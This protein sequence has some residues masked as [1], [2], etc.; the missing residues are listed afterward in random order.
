M[1]AERGSVQRKHLSPTDLAEVRE[2]LRQEGK[3]VVQ[4]H[5][6]FDIVHPGHIRYL[7]F[8]RERGDILI[9]SVSGDDVVG[10][11]F[12]RPYINEELRVE[13]LAALEFVD[14]V[15]VDHNTWAGPVLELLRPDIYV[16]GK[17]YETNADPRFLKEKALVEANGGRVVFS[18]GEVVFSSSTIIG[19]YQQRFGMD[20]ER[21]DFFCRRN[22]IDGPALA[23]LLEDIAGRRLLVIGDPILDR[24]ITC[25]ASAVASESPIL[26]VRP[27]GEA[28][29]AG[30]AGLIAAQVHA[31]GAESSLLTVLP[32]SD[33]ARRFIGVL[34]GCGVEVLSIEA[35]RRPVY[36]KTRYLVDETKVF[37]VNEGHSAPLSSAD[38]HAL[39]QLLQREAGRFDGVVVTDFG[40]GLFGSELI[41][42]IERILARHHIPCFADVSISG[43]ANILKFPAARLSTPNEQELRF[44]FGDHES[45]LSNLASRYFKATAAERLVLTMGNRGVVVF[46]RPEEGSQRLTTDHLPAF[47]RHAVDTVGGG[48]VLLAAMAAS[49]VA[50]HPTPEGLY[51]GSCLAA[52]Q[53]GRMGNE[54]VSLDD[55]QAFLTERPELR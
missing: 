12:D 25:E 10:K 37:K 21:V 26:S 47:A 38:V 45:G 22:G 33:A 24:Y 8:A 18:S 32:R 55:L 7:R 28:W 17:E 11:G 13:N 16:K 15:C 51:L 1:A 50:G 53:V 4:C 49:H 48:D 35:E 20:Q 23:R 43:Q 52:V 19:R 14:F 54:S 42:G 3:V 40:F 46:H 34:E 39:D 9:V 29:Y 36:V 31:L 30:G 2:R 27:A 41:Q 44:A 5:G 6:C